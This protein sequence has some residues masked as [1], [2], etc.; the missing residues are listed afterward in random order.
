MPRTGCRCSPLSQFKYAPGFWH[1]SHPGD[2]EWG[3]KV[4]MGVD[5][6]AS[7]DGSH[8]LAEARQAMLVC[9]AECRSQG[10]FP[11]W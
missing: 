11:F 7:N 8:L 3:V 5:G 10:R 2:A 4:G 9:A 1:C 6:S